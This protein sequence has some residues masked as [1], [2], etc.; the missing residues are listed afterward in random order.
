MNCMLY[1]PLKFQITSQPKSSDGH[2][3][4][5]RSRFMTDKVLKAFDATVVHGANGDEVTLGDVGNAALDVNARLK[6]MW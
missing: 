3:Y 4:G 1:S 5:G 6:E 2:V